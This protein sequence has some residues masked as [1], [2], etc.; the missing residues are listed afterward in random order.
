MQISF[1]MLL[2]FDQISER[3]K[4]FQGGN[5]LKGAPPCP[6]PPPPPWKKARLQICHTLYCAPTVSFRHARY[7]YANLNSNSV[8]LYF[9]HMLTFYFGY[10]CYHT[11]YL[12][13]LL[14]ICQ[15]LYCTPTLCFGYT[16]HSTARPNTSP[17]TC[18]TL[19]CNPSTLLLICS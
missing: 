14:L 13:T 3:G 5:C 15:A 7:C 2:F 12:S 18:W 17:W 6:P 10:A 8:T 16:R 4:S 9:G 11:P 1:V 19:Y